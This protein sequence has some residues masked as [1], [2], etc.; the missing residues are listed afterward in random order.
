[1]SAEQ[2]AEFILEHR[3]TVKEFDFENVAL[4]E[5]G[6]WDDALAPL[7]R[8]SGSEDWMAQGSGSENET[9]SSEQGFGSRERLAP[10]DEEEMEEA[11]E[12][13][14]QEAATEAV[15]TSIQVKTRTRHRRRKR[16]PTHPASESRSNKSRLQISDPIPISVPIEEVLIPESDLL[17]K[18]AVFNPNAAAVK[19]LDPAV[20]GVQRNAEMDERM[21][22][23]ADDP[24]KR[25]STL[26]KAKA[27]VLKQLGREF[28]GGKERKDSSSSGRGL[29][30]SCGSYGTAM[31]GK[32]AVLGTRSRMF[33]GESTTALVPLMFSR[34]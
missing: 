5:G 7:T 15:R 33:F 27:R 21:K 26:Q 11:L 6:D 29:F 12:A 17:L 3:H 28:C 8:V 10:L 23:L 22:E 14:I 25:E 24:E 31:S 4:R 19:G 20:Q 16:K 1:M 13:S 34:Y 30:G 32:A 9:S 18:P 2:V